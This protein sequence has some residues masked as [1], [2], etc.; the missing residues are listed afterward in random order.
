MNNKLTSKH[1]LIILTMILSGGIFWN[2]RQTWVMLAKQE[3]ATQS[4]ESGIGT[5]F[6]KPKGEDRRQPLNSFLNQLHDSKEF[7]LSDAINS[8]PNQGVL[9]EQKTIVLQSANQAVARKPSLS[10]EQAAY[11]E[12]GGVVRHD[13]HPLVLNMQSVSQPSQTA[14]ATLLQQPTPAIPVA[15]SLQSALNDPTASGQATEIMQNPESQ[16]QLHE[17][18]S[19]FVQ[20][21]NL[22]NDSPY[23]ANYAQHY[24]QSVDLADQ[25]FYAIYGHEA[26]ISMDAV[27]ATA[28]GH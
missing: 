26:Y 8:T 1:L 27:R 7:V 12:K 17:I 22:S 18:A 6:L 19:D 10:H 5:N 24:N 15:Y 13:P 3:N 20:R 4:R 23:S 16:D 25:Q 21:V 2:L 9:I 14:D 11:Q 28:E